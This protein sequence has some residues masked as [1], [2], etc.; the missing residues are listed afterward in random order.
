[1]NYTHGPIMSKPEMKI[2]DLM[3]FTSIALSAKPQP[4]LEQQAF[5]PR[6]YYHQGYFSNISEYLRV[7]PPVYFGVKNYNC[8]LELNDATFIGAVAFMVCSGTWCTGTFIKLGTS[9]G[10]SFRLD[11]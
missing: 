9:C 10:I 11:G 6:D 4:S 5:L 7:G 1:M 2:T 3:V 8:S